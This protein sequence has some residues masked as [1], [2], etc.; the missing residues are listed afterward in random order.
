M[1][2]ITGATGFI[3]SRVARRLLE[4]G[5]QVRLLVR[6]RARADGLARLGA[7][8]IEGAVTDARTHLQGLHGAQAAIHL[9]A[10]YDIGI[11]DAAAI[12]RTNVDGTRALLSAAEQAG[13]PRVVHVSSNAALGPV[14]AAPTEP[15]DA[16]AG[17][18]HSAY[19]RSKAESHQLAR[20]A[21]HAGRPVIIVCPSFV[22]G[23]G[24]EGPAGRFIKDLVRRRVP[25]LL[26][27]PAWFSYVHVDDVADGIVAALDRGAPGEVYLLTGE[28]STMNDFAARVARFAQVKPPR[29]RLPV[30]LA[31]GLAAVLDPLSRITH[32][33]FPM[34]RETVR[35]TVTDRW[36]HTHER[37][38]RDLGYQP[39]SLDSGLPETVAWALA[40]T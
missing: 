17:P 5:E 28:A 26:S 16:Y 3:G 38:T 24:D 20:A 33:R 11:V 14:R 35:T 8:L 22:Y 34:T 9:A 23:P 27:R 10:I 25:A 1:I 29:L 30:G 15:V 19:H 40:N 18:F 2:Y 21:Q 13:T 39:R 32:M 36:L 12:Q 6:S 4:R 7:E 37:A 31:R